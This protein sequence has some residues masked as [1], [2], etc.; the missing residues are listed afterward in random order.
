MTDRPQ[1]LN[2]SCVI[3]TLHRYLDKLDKQPFDARSNR[4]TESISQ[5]HFPEL[6]S[7]KEPG[8]DEVTWHHLSQ[9]EEYGI[10]E[11]ERTL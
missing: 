7:P 6:F 5:N 10:V 11:F 9:L 1:C 8:D 4:F 2:N 3:R